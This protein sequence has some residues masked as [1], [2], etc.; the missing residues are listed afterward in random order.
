MK[1]ITP[2]GKEIEL[3]YEI[4]SVKIGP[5]PTSCFAVYRPELCSR[6][7]IRHYQHLLT[8]PF[9]VLLRLHKKD[10]D[11]SIIHFEPFETEEEQQN[12]YNHCIE[13]Y[14]KK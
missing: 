8:K 6:D 2:R 10:N 1:Y 4:E 11:P 5:T 7:D 3:E 9:S 13:T 14:L 12:W